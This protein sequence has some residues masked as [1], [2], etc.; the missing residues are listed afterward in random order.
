MND[1]DKFILDN[2]VNHNGQNLL[3][4]FPEVCCS[5]IYHKYKGTG[6]LRAAYR[7]YKKFEKEINEDYKRDLELGW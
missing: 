6:K 1:R 4:G 2:C 7:A 5:C 3:C